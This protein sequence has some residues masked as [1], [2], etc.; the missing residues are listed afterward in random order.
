MFVY[1]KHLLFSIH[2]MK[3]KENKKICLLNI[4]LF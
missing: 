1:N 4:V 3:V 2:G